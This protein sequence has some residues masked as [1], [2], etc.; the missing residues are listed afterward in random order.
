MP[1]E[2]GLSWRSKAVVFTAFCS[3]PVN[4]ARLDVNVSAIRNFMA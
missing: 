2:A 3:S 1:G 4:F